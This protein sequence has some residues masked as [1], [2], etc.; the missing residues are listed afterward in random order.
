MKHNIVESKTILFIP[1]SDITI[2]VEKQ[3]DEVI[4]LNFM[5]GEEMDE[6][7]RNFSNNDE[8]LLKFYN[9]T[10]LSIAANDEI[11]LFQ[12]VIFAYVRYKD[13]LY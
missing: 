4:G 6:F 3:A 12:E 8:D 2:M 9:A 10:K 5:F 13:E 7:H 11:E 1:Q